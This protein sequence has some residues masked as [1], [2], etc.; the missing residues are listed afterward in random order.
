M[1]E[2]DQMG[3]LGPAC[4]IG[5]AE[6]GE[7]MWGRAVFLLLYC[8]SIHEHNMFQLTS[9]SL[10]NHIRHS[11][12]GAGTVKTVREVQVEGNGCDLL[13]SNPLH[14]KYVCHRYPHI[15]INPTNESATSFLGTA[16]ILI[17]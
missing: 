4:P 16:I 8:D 1:G 14:K 15:K 5:T 7:R 2:E 17:L 9:W 6:V 11:F 10:D 13:M 3:D 12:L